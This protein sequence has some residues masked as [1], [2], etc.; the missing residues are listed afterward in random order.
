MVAKGTLPTYLYIY[1]PNDHTGTGPNTI[2]SPNIPGA[3]GPEEI[4]DGDTGLGMV[5]QHLMNSPVYY[6]KASGTGSAIF[7]TY[8]DAQSGRDH[9]DPHRTPLIVVSPFAKLNTNGDGTGYVATHHYSTASIV[10][11]EE[12]LMGLP[13]NNYGDLFATDLRDLFQPTYNGITASRIPFNNSNTGHLYVATAE[14][15]RVW[16]LASLCDSSAPDRDSRRLSL[17][18]MLSLQADTLHHEAARKGHLHTAQYR[19]TQAKI[20]RVAERVVSGG[21]PADGDD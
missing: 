12:L 21:T 7:I 4:S 16:K 18:G 13:P 5:V 2:A 9:I 19:A 8:D 20:L 11:T 17:I 1:Q 15:R 6:D 10:K 14:G 3:T